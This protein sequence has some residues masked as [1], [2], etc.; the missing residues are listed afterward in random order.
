[1]A[2]TGEALNIPDAYQDP[3]F[4]PE[5]DK[6]TGYHTRNILCMPVFDSGG[7][8]IAVTQLNQQSPGHLHRFR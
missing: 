5:A 8:L 1:M 3:R 4:N 2:T 6:R 7:K